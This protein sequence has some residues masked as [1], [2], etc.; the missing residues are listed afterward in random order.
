MRQFVK[1]SEKR[2]WPLGV[3]YLDA[4][5]YDA[6]ED[7][8]LVPEFLHLLA[9]ILDGGHESSLQVFVLRVGSMISD[10][11]AVKYGA[12]K[13]LAGLGKHASTLRYVEVVLPSTLLLSVPWLKLNRLEHV[14]VGIESSDNME[15]HEFLEE[16]GWRGLFPDPESGVVQMPSVRSVKLCNAKLPHIEQCL[17]LFPNARSFSKD[18]FF[19]KREL[20]LLGQQM[21]YM[22]P[23]PSVY[24][25][26]FV[27]DEDQP[28]AL[29]RVR[30]QLNLIVSPI[31]S[32]AEKL[33]NL[34]RAYVS[35]C[36]SSHKHQADLIMNETAQLNLRSDQQV[37]TFSV[38]I[39]E[40]NFSYGWLC[41][42]HQAYVSMMERNEAL[43][44]ARRLLIDVR[45]RDA[46]GAKRLTPVLP[47][48]M[49]ARK[50]YMPMLQEFFHQLAKNCARL[51][52]L[53]YCVGGSV[54]NRPLL[55]CEL[56]RLELCALR[57]GKEI[58]LRELVRAALLELYFDY[59]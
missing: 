18:V 25:D 40:E 45:Y 10:A 21:H 39:S 43:R 30:L 2:N 12:E 22:N 20:A 42:V 32:P 48:S 15:D 4:T 51:R 17:E 27:E 1:L 34:R 41:G 9:R 44:G 26:K 8:Q 13:L 49:E 11:D 58:R 3:F 35:V 16:N 47:P 7:E 6:P 14:G 56:T 54:I 28:T 38:D 50:E 46:H 55:K 29:R 37:E 57:K 59:M 24:L 36:S 19:N 31:W 23:T 52:S 5:C 33:P 53:S